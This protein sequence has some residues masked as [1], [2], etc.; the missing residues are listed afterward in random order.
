[1]ELPYPGTFTPE[2]ESENDVKHSLPE[3]KMACNFHSSCPK[4]VVATNCTHA[5][6]GSQDVIP[7]KRPVV[8]ACGATRLM[9]SSEAI[10]S[11]NQS[12]W[13]QARCHAE[14]H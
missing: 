10:L 8:E 14:Y 13:N 5:E 1:M 4:M 9:R 12:I 11:R 7:C 2:S 3:E 6:H